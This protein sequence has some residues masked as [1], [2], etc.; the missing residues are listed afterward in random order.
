MS[1][2]RMSKIENMDPEDKQHRIVGVLCQDLGWS[3]GSCEA[4]G[5]DQP[6]HAELHLSHCGLSLLLWSLAAPHLCQ[7]FSPFRMWQ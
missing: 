5:T 3:R 1:T 7:G 4:P 2:K 6:L